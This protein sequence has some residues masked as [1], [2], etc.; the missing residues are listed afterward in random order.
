MTTP[1]PTLDLIDN[2]PGWQRA[3][4]FLEKEISQRRLRDVADLGGGANPLLP[5]SFVEAQKLN[6]CVLDIS[7]EELAKAPAFCEKIQIDITAPPEEFRGKVRQEQFDL[8][9]SHMFLE[10]IK[11]PMRAHQNIHSMLRHD[12]IAIHFYPSPNNLPLAL[13]RLIPEGLSR[14]LLR[15][16]QPKRDLGGIQG[17]FPA[18]YEMCGNPSR[19]AHD[20]FA[21]LGYRVIQHTGYIGHG[22][23]D[24]FPPLRGMELA[25]RRVLLAAGLGLTSATLLILQ[26]R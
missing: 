5:E 2:F 14:Q 21:E 4:A 15:I 16:A 17:K 13:N 22:Y 6:Y 8:V 7:R 18:Y 3:P 10:H 23:Y 19:Q 24:R 11:S 25:L 1:L 26:K 12:G 9:F 20:R